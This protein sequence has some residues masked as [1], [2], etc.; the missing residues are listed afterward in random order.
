MERYAILEAEDGIEALTLAEEHDP[1]LV[2]L[3]VMMPRMNGYETCRRL[4]DNPATHLIPVIMVTALR[5][6]TDRIKGID[7]GADEFLSRPH[8]RAE[9]MVRV[10]T[11]IRLKHTR[12]D[13]QRE[14]HSLQLLYDVSRA[15]N[16]ELDLDKMMA[17]IITQTQTA[18]NATK[19]NLMLIDESNNVISKYLVRSGGELN[20][21]RSV[22]DQVMRDGLGGWLLRNQKGCIIDDITKDERWKHLPDDMNGGGS[23]VGIPLSGPKRIMGLLILNNPQT[24]YFKPE[25][26][27]LLET[28]GTTVA[29]AIENASLFQEISEERR[30]MEAIL[31]QSTDAIITT[32]EEWRIDLCNQAAEKMFSIDAAAVRGELL[33]SIVMLSGVA[34]LSALSSLEDLNGR[35]VPAELQLKNGKTLYLTVSPIDAVGYA[36]VMQDVTEFKR[37]EA[38]RL[39]R[40][41]SEKTAVR[42]TFARYMGPAVVDH[43]LSH[44]PGL[45]GRLEQRRAIVMFA[46]L[47][48]WTGGMI[49]KIAPEQAVQQL[50]AYFTRMMEIAVANDGTVF[51][52][53]GDELLVGFNAP[54][55]QP[56]A[57]HL[58]V[59]TAVE[60]QVAFNALRQQWHTDAGMT[61]GLGIGIDEG[62]IV[63]GNVGAESRLSFRMV[64]AAMNTAHR[65]VDL[66]ED[67]QIVISKQVHDGFLEEA[68]KW[69]ETMTFHEKENVKLK[70]IPEPQFLY[71]LETK[72]PLLN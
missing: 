15:I 9:L 21:S 45:L 44:E 38:L 13:L 35:F 36:I 29:A 41:Q 61:L 39:E 31:T 47:R 49:S 53:T 46:D 18:V 71:Y 4:K 59:K 7:A 48:N 3:D 62:D 51:E 25:D 32:D 24:E 55:D 42:E 23:A 8:V 10:R 12:A 19:G 65:L 67:G 43:V 58:A 17:A 60:M 54:L 57:H 22:N 11:L 20:I 14:R 5:D 52:L 34:Q 72:R 16:A 50:N 6:V 28:M 30:K 56:N 40:E 37:I 69:A 70:G 2:L 1:D 68:A 64:G 66:A 26:L 33:M 63:M 27:A